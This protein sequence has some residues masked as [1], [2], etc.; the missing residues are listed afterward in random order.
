MRV[1]LDTNILIDYISEREPFTEDARSIIR[2]CMEK[3]LYGCISAHTVTNTFY[4]LRKE[5]SVSQ[6]KHFLLDMCRFLAVAGLDKE[7]LVSALENESFTD[8]EDC[9]QAECAKEF[10]ADY[11]VTRN[12]KDFTGSSIPAITPGDF[13]RLAEGIQQ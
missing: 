12:V 8:V 4:I 13:I 3:D 2:M 10:G 7:L 11:I 6:R 9:L 1:L 5:L